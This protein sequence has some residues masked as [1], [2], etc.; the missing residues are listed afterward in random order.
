MPQEDKQPRQKA[1][2]GKLETVVRMVTGS[3][4]LSHRESIA[5]TSTTT[6][7]PSDTHSHNTQFTISQSQITIA[8]QKLGWLK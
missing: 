5:T 3:L 1:A 8:K 6:P 2:E 7:L 4:A